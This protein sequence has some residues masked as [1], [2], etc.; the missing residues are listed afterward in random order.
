MR[1]VVSALGGFFS[2]LKLNTLLNRVSGFIKEKSFINK[3]K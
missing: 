3:Y 2:S 1:A